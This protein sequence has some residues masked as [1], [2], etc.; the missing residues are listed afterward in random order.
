ML[1]SGSKKQKYQI[2]SYQLSQKNLY[3]ISWI[4]KP[5]TQAIIWWVMAWIQG[6]EIQETRIRN[7]ERQ[8]TA[9]VLIF[10]WRETGPGTQFCETTITRK[11]DIFA[12]L[13]HFQA[14]N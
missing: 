12:F 5:R 6:F 14:K 7:F 4:S 3:P 11:F 13:S 8:E 9:W 1:V 2:F 10:W